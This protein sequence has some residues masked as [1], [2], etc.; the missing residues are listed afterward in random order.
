MTDTWASVSEVVCGKIIKR[1]LAVSAVRPELFIEPYDRIIELIQ[2]G[3][4]TVTQEDIIS[5]VGMNPVMAAL[6]AATA[7]ENHK[8][9]IEWIALL[10]GVAKKCILADKLRRH[11]KRLDQGE[12]VETIEL[13]EEF[14]QYEGKKPYM[15]PLDEIEKGDSPFISSGWDAIDQEFGGWPK[16]GLIT[17]GA[18]PKVGKTSFMSKAAIKFVQ[19]YPTKKV[20]I[21]TLEMRDTEY[22]TRVEDLRGDL[23]QE[24]LHRIVVD[25]TAG[26]TVAEV[27][28]KAARE[29]NLGFVAV[30]F[31]D[32][33]IQDENNESEMAK[34]YRTLANL[35][36]SLGIPVMLLSQ[37]NRSYSGGVPLPRHIRYTSMA[38]ALSWMLCVLYDPRKD[39]GSK[40]DAVT[41]PVV[42]GERIT[43]IVGWLIRGG[44]INHPDDNPG[45]IA[46]NFHGKTGW[47][48]S[49]LGWNL[50]HTE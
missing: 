47:G 2:K 45:A 49:S 48:D 24:Q 6:D 40:E 12:D 34:I 14:R 46:V 35:A 23:T 13:V 1:K 33:M 3:E 44:F 41:L 36:K 7:A 29:P 38:E 8:G 27:A 21:F 19:R 26:M 9:D 16:A 30:D 50:L 39:F 32:L 20:G 4:G 25:D 42:Q 15:T 28:N 37:F 5:K 18:S 43:Y 11:A 17:I 31:A 22:R 10:E